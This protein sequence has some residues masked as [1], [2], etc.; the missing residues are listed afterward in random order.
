MRGIR[1]RRLPQGSKPAD[2]RTRR[3]LG[4]LPEGRRQHFVDPAPNRR[5]RRWPGWPS[6]ATATLVVLGLGLLWRTIRYALAFPLWG[7]EAFL[8]LSLVTRSLAGLSQPLEFGQI[9]PPGFL[10]AEWGVVRLLGT[11]EGALRLLPYLA[12]VGS[13]VLFWRF[14]R[15]IAGRRV[16]LVAV[17]LLAASFYPARHGNEVKPYAVDM[18]VALVL[19]TLGWRVW[20]APRSA[21]RWVA[22]AVAGIVGVWCSYPAIFPA[23]SILALTGVRAWRERASRAIG[24]ASAC[25]LLVAANWAVM[26]WTFALPQAS[27]SAWLPD[28]L[29]WRDAF[30]PLARPWRLPWW[31]LNVHTGNMLAYPHGGNHFGSTLTFL[32]VTTGTWRLWRQPKHRALLW[33]WLGPL[34]FALAA[35]ALR[36]Y[37]YGTSARVMLYM[38]PA[39]CFLA[40]EGIVTLLRAWD[41]RALRYGPQV[42]A[43]LLSLAVM[44]WTATD[45][46]APYARKSDQE[47]RQRIRQLAASTRPGDR[48]VVFDGATPLPQVPDLMLSLW[49]QRLAEFRYD[50]RSNAPVP[51]DWE[52]D[53]RAVTPSPGGRVWLLVHHHGCGWIYPGARSAAYRDAFAGRFGPAVSA[54]SWSVDRA[55]LAVH[56]YRP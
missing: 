53:P 8:A 44:A 22:L 46:H 50:V 14:C 36:K 47:M 35:A 4:G 38:A 31:L 48:W 30:P 45:L 29:T 34:A 1:A 19:T 20:L 51:V 10:W 27:A 21:T 41:R 5:G 26:T 39:F 16:V 11:G 15:D 52:P 7:D 28:L 32:L 56:L 6:A 2:G 17:A 55:T 9:A 37:P 3:R 42:I 25:L 23:A 49:V 54:E 43:G 18:L 13:L 33:L 24:W 12:S 40:A